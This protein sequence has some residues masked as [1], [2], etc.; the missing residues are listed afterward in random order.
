MASGP[1][2]SFNQVAT[3]RYN[4]AGIRRSFG[5][6]LIR[7]APHKPKAGQRPGLWIAYVSANFILSFVCLMNGCN[8]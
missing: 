5:F 3:W 8:K 4:N 1:V 2:G 7:Q 6:G